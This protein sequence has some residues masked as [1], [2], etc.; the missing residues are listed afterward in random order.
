MVGYGLRSALVFSLI[1]FSTPPHLCSFAKE[2]TR[3]LLLLLFRM[4]NFAST[5]ISN[6]S[7]QQIHYFFNHSLII[8]FNLNRKNFWKLSNNLYEHEFMLM[9]HKHQIKML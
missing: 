5:N 1:N 6:I 2:K 3:K 7:M 4:S 9:I 8:Y